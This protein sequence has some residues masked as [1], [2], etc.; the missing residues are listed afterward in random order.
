MEIKRFYNFI[1]EN[2]E[3]EE[4]DKIQ[5]WLS[6][7]SEYFDDW[8]W[9]GDLLTLFL[10]GESIEKYTKEELEEENIIQQDN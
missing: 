1:L 2:K 3:Q 10:D 8:D 7:T 6:N 5:S 4:L 9:D